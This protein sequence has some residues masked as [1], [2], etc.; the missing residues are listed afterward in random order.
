MALKSSVEVVTRMERFVVYV[1]AGGVSLAAGL[2]LVTLFETQAPVWWLGA[3]LIVL[4]LAGLGGGIA[5]QV[6][7]DP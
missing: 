4:G 3:A 2:W 5:S 6:D 7:P 1:V